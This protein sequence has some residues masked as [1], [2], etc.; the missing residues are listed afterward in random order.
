MCAIKMKRPSEQEMQEAYDRFEA[1]LLSKDTK[2]ENLA[3]QVGLEVKNCLSS[4]SDLSDTVKSQI[5]RLVLDGVMNPSSPMLML[6]H[7]RLRNVLCSYLRVSNDDDGEATRNFRS[8]L[9]ESKM[10]FLLPDL[11]RL[12]HPKSG[13]IVRAGRSRSSNHMRSNSS[14]ENVDEEGMLRKLFRHHW[15]VHAPYYIPI[16][17]FGAQDRAKELLN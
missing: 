14:R 15:A 1:L 12:A 5:N 8:V 17:V 2:I 13:I 4:S 16:V 10:Q 6:L 3:L 9:A 11:K 7:K